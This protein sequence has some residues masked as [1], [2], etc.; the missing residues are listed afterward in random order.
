M[1]SIAV[2]AAVAALQLAA[3]GGDAA[4]ESEEMMAEG[5]ADGFA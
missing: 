1:R 5:E 2:L 4:Q 3:C